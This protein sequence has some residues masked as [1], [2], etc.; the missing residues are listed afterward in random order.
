MIS[1][2]RYIVSLKKVARKFNNNKNINW[3]SWYAQYMGYE[4]MWDNYL[5]TFIQEY[6]KEPNRPCIHFVFWESC[7]GGTPFPHQNYAFNPSRHS[8]P[9]NGNSDKY[10]R[11]VCWKFGIELDKHITIGAL[12]VELAKKGILIIDLYPTHGVSLDTGNRKNLF[13]NVFPDYSLEKLTRVGKLIKKFR[14]CETIRVTSELFNSGL[15]DAMDPLLIEKIRKALSLK[16][17]PKFIVIG[18]KDTTHL[19]GPSST[20]S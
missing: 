10:L 18:Q 1:Q 2:K 16:N 19:N 20:P 9:H 5:F 13:K 14:K 7:P 17:N 4:L 12:M 15:E 3:G 11:S 8:I 6:A